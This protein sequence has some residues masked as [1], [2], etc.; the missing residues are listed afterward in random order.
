MKPLAL[1]IGPVAFHV[2]LPS[3]AITQEASALYQDYPAPTFAGFADYRLAVRFTSGWRGWT[4]RQITVTGDAPIPFT[5]LPVHLAIV[6]AE[7]GMNY[8][9]AMGLNRLLLLHASGVARDD[10]AILFSAESGSGKSTLAAALAL[11]DWRLLS[12][13]FGLVAP[14]TDLVWP[15]PRPVSLKNRSIDILQALAPA[16][17]FSARYPGTP[18]GTL[19]YMRPPADAIAGMLRPARTRAVVFPLFD[20]GAEPTLERLTA[21][22]CF[23]RLS[24][25]ST[26][27]TVLGEAA[28]ES[29]W[30][31]SQKPVF[32]ITYPDLESARTLVQQV[33][34]E[35]H[36]D[37]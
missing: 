36:H 34:R 1:Q 27:A 15:C 37:G 33:W 9:I 2:T 35:S 26:N 24:A 19:C 29:L 30:L 16:D 28:F 5:P 25:S 10:E 17:R 32:A 8:H 7:M 3:R 12:D 23:V 13:E 6:A 18:K 11:D 14:G 21:T 20:A 31:L 22:E 4:A